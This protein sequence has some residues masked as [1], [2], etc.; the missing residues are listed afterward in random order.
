MMGTNKPKP[1][2]ECTKNWTLHDDNISPKQLEMASKY[3]KLQGIGRS[4]HENNIQMKQCGG[5]WDI[6][7]KV[8]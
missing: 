8:K 6:K 1:R 3:S 7:R 2:R 4:D 5:R